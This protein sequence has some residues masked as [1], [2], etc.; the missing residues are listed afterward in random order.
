[1]GPRG[2]ETEFELTT[3]ERLELLGYRYSHGDDLTRPEEEVVLVDILREKLTERYGDIPAAAIEESVRRFSH[4]EGVDTLRRNMAFHEAITRGIELRIEHPGGRVDH[5]HIYPIDWDN[6]DR[7]DFLVVNQLR[8]HGNNDRRPDLVVFVNGLPLIVFELK[9][10]YSAKPTVEEALN[11]IAH[12][13]NDIP[14]LFEFNALTSVSDGI[15]TLHGVWTATPEWY[16][17][18]KSIDGFHVEA[19]TTGSMKTL[20][21]GLFRKQVLLRY[22]RHFLVFE[23]VNDQ[24]TKKGAKYHQF[25]AVEL[26]S[27]KTIEAF[28]SDTDRRIGVIWHTTGSGKSL[29]MAFLVGILRRQL[30][31]PTF[32]IEVDRTDLDDQLHDQFV[33]A[34]SLVGD[35]KHADSVDDLR[36]LVRTEGGEVI[37]TTIE[38]FRLKT[39][40]GELSHPVLSERS[41]IVLIADEAHRSQYGFLKGYARYLAE[42]LPNAK[43]LGFTGTP[44]SFSGSDTVEVFGDL[45]HTYDIRQ[46]QEDHATVPIYYTPRLVHLHLGQA[47][48]DAAL[49][50]ITA[51]QDI[52]ELERKKSRWAALAAA[53]G[54][55]DRMAAVARDLL[56]HFLDRT[57]TLKGKAIAVCMT[58]DNC[59]RLYGALTALPGC[60]EMKIV[61]TGDLGKDPPSGALQATS[62][63]SPRAM[64]SSRGSSIPT[65]RSKSSS[66]AT[67][68]SRGRTF[69][70]STRSTS[71]SR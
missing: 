55:K 5:R 50:E 59:V 36:D 48:I 64:L 21:E 31:N 40:E 68:G 27:A 47:D 42:A 14:Q 39:D 34:R 15:K 63:P 32:V 25:F 30:Q 26:A 51:G 13:R 54:A 37:F 44:I 3:I 8:I 28:Q 22:I 71:T 7:N 2:T 65:I 52:T 10:P 18:W 46:S 9:N 24:I 67:C 35:V 60:P 69:R 43:R 20:I 6:P 23:V 58:R 38:K 12:Y 70:A 29:S 41:N 57:K 45:I 49:Q 56:D 33:A 17:P 61:M 53:A 19:N 4:P 62:P 1:M 16:A 11:Q 66:C